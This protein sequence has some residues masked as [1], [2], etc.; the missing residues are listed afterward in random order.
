MMQ[1]E[2]HTSACPVGGIAPGF[3]ELLARGNLTHKVQQAQM[4]VKQTARNGVPVIGQEV[5]GTEHA[6]CCTF[7]T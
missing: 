7:N 4:S 2:A 6:D 5:G 1:A 3:L